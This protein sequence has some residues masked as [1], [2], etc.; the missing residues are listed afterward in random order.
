MY[1]FRSPEVQ[2]QQCSVAKKRNEREY[3]I[4]LRELERKTFIILTVTAIGSALI[5][6]LS[7][8]VAQAGEPAQTST[9]SRDADSTTQPDQAKYDALHAKA[10]ED[11]EA[12]RAALQEALEQSDEDT[13]G[14]T[15]TQQ[16]VDEEY[17]RLDQKWKQARAASEE[18]Q[19]AWEK[20][21]D[22]MGVGRK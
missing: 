12:L 18:S 6:G 21:K 19:A 4:L 8:Q 9:P 10:D 20:A 22:E 3:M 5:G 11:F 14:P 13:V 17:M 7:S 15:R 1:R 2:L 16:E